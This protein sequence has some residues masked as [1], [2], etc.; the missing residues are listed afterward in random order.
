MSAEFMVY[1]ECQLDGK[2]LSADIDGKIHSIFMLK[3]YIS[4]NVRY[5]HFI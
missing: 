4:S 3:Q 1:N 5:T 2:I